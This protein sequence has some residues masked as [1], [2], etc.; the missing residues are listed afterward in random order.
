[1][2][3][4]DFKSLVQ[5]SVVQAIRPRELLARALWFPRHLILGAAQSGPTHQSVT[6]IKTKTLSLQNLSVISLF[7]C[8]LALTCTFKV[9]LS[10][11]SYGLDLAPHCIISHRSFAFTERLLEILRIALRL[12]F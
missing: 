1:M 12:T 2:C 7:L 6:D 5:V 11:S 8:I 10:I 3:W 4:S 9:Q